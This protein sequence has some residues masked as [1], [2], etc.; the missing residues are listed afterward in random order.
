MI[1]LLFSS[2]WGLVNTPVPA[3]QEVTGTVCLTLSGIQ[4]D[5]RELVQALAKKPFDEKDLEAFN[6]ECFEVDGVRYVWD[7]RIYSAKSSQQRIDL[8]KKLST[9]GLKMGD[10]VDLGDYFGAVT[11]SHQML[12]DQFGLTKENLEGAT[13]GVSFVRRVTIEAPDGTRTNVV[14]SQADLAERLKPIKPFSTSDGKEKAENEARAKVTDGEINV[15]FFGFRTEPLDAMKSA[16]LCFEFLNSLQVKERDQLLL[17]VDQ[18]QSY[19]QASYPDLANGSSSLSARDREKI[20]LR[21]S[22]MAGGKGKWEGYKVIGS[23]TKPSLEV[24]F[25][26]GQRDNLIFSTSPVMLL[27]APSAPPKSKIKP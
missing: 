13:A 23:E 20:D 24:S 7:S 3:S 15:R 6:L 16:G 2:I 5:Q 8:W 14:I 1:P 27:D 10:I 22:L 25:W 12:A 9:G 18:F 19:L 21:L 4:I 17:L 11:S 26:A